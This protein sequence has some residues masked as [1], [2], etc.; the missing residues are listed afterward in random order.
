M[1]I[2]GIKNKYIRR[3]IL[4]ATVPFLFTFGAGSGGID[5]WRSHFRLGEL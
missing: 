2:T 1:S 3:T 4:V 5:P